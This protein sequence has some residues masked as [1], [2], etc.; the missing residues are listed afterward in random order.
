MQHF[1]LHTFLGQLVP[2]WLVRCS[3]PTSCK[4]VLDRI[5]PL[6]DHICCKVTTGALAKDPLK[7][8]GSPNLYPWSTTTE[9]LLL[10]LD[11]SWEYT[12]PLR[13]PREHDNK[14]SAVEFSIIFPLPKHFLS[15]LATQRPLAKGIN[16]L[17]LSNVVDESASCQERCIKQ[18]Y[19]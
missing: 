5:G 12:S 4:M 13:S 15:Y 18:N 6:E 10:E 14:L 16:Q 17:L 19:L 7:P 11:F 1:S 8:K 2:N 3:I 9:S